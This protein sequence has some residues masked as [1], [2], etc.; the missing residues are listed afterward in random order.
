LKN[1]LNRH[2][3][4]GTEFTG[5]C[6]PGSLKIFIDTVGNLNVCE[7]IKIN[8]IIGH[9]EHGFDVGK[10]R[11][12][13]ME[14]QNEVVKTKCWRCEFWFICNV[15]LALHLKDNKVKLNC[16]LK[17]KGEI[18]IQQFISGMESD[19]PL[20]KPNYLNSEDYLGSLI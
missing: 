6:F 19:M 18:V 17:K 4:K 13:W 15:C 7:R 3:R 8:N 14:W 1:K 16:Q 9:V 11:K 20:M 10:I 12:I 5:M 2:L